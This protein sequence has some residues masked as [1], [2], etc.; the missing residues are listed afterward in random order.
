MSIEKINKKI[1]VG[2]DANRQAIILHLETSQSYRE[3]DNFY[4]GL[5]GEEYDMNSIFTEAEGEQQAK[6]YIEDDTEQWK[7]EVA[8]D[9]TLQS[10]DEWCEDRLRYDSWQ[11]IIGDV[12][13]IGYDK[14][15][16][17]GEC[18]YVRS[19]G[20]GQIDMHMNWQTYIH[21][22]VKKEDVLTIA[23]AWKKLHLKEFTKMLPYELKLAKDVVEIFKKYP[24]FEGTEELIKYKKLVEQTV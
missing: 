15:E 3:E 1:L 9:Q 2:L 13:C 10:F 22:E 11:E 12:Y 16:D 23:R 24:E 18:Y 17:L 21:Y 20:F 7:M 8:D 4:L 6:E 19:G 14:D 5:T